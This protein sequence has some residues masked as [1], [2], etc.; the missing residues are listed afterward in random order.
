MTD[1][2][3]VHPWVTKRGTDELLPTQD[4]V[5]VIVEPPTEEE[6]NAA[7]TG[8]MGHLITVV[9]ANCP[10]FESSIYQE[11]PSKSMTKFSIRF[12]Q[13]NVSSSSYSGADLSSWKAFLVALPASSNHPFRFVLITCANLSPKTPPTVDLLKA[14]SRPKVSTVTLASQTTVMFSLKLSL[15]ILHQA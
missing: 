3:K 11:L 4:N 10:Y 5:A 12:E 1:V 9:S 14:P 2:L 13:S 15:H 6:V 7:I 8:N